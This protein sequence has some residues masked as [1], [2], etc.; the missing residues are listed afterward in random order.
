MVKMFSSGDFD[1]AVEVG[2]RIVDNDAPLKKQ[3][4]TIFGCDYSDLK[5][6]DKHVG[7]HLVALGD[8]EHYGR[9]R[10]GDAFSKEACVKYHETFVKYGHVYRHHRNKDPKKSIGTIKA[11]AYNDRMGRIELYIHADKEKAASELER[12]EK[13]GDHPYSMACIVDYDV[14]SI[15]GNHRKQAGDN[16]ECEHIRSHLGDLMDDGKD[17]FTFNPEP[18]FFDISFVGRPADRIAWNLKVASDMA[19]SSVKLAEM[20][21]VEPPDELAITEPSA[22]RKLSYAR[23]LSQ[24]QGKYRGLLTKRATADTSSDRY[25]ME[26]AKVASARIPDD[27]VDRLR[28]LPPKLAFSVLGKSGVVMD[29]P[30]FFKYAMG[31]EYG[32]VEQYVPEI[33]EK[34]AEVLDSLVDGCDLAGICNDTT[35]DAEDYSDA[36]LQSKLAAY[37]LM[38]DLEDRILIATLDEARPVFTKR[39][40]ALDT[41]PQICEN[42]I[43]SRLASRYLAYKLA[44]IDAVANGRNDIDKTTLLALAATQNL[45]EH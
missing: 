6:D 34:A 5:P 29:V 22:L 17:V 43:A 40:M 26:L 1:P 28:E 38:D 25:F 10:N 12:L 39:A 11:A 15:C 14:C 45:Q 31:P 35:F 19:T 21:D 7:I 16:T 44:A 27:L 37:G 24:L 8:Y 33:T 3:A 20:A 13:E 32:Q 41:T 2:M 9:N 18:K 42:T 4:S 36:G 23:E 30:T